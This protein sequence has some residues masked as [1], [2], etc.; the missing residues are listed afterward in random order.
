MNPDRSYKTQNAAGRT[1]AEEGIT[2]EVIGG[3][4][5]TYNVLGFGFRES[6][7][8]RALEIVLRGRG[9][10]VGREFPIEVFFRGEQI[11]F[12]RADMLVEGRVLVEVKATTSSFTPT[13]FS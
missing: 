2:R 10:S 13:S 9:L 1:L 11:G 7:Y 12:Y 4:Y 3:F 8:K 6:L 5:E